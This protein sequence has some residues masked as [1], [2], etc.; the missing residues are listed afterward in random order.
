MGKKGKDQAPA[1]ASAGSFR[2]TRDYDGFMIYEWMWSPDGLGLSLFSSELMLYAKIYSVSHHNTGALTASQGKLAELFGLTRESV[3]RVLK[4]L[5]SRGLIYVCGT[6]RAPGHAGRAVNV[7]AVCQAPINR[8]VRRAPS[9][10]EANQ[11]AQSDPAGAS[12]TPGSRSYV[13]AE[14]P[15]NVTEESPL[16]VT[17]SANVSEASHTQNSHLAGAQPDGA[18]PQ[19]AN[20]TN[21]NEGKETGLPIACR[22]LTQTELLTFESLCKMSLK[23][24]R[25]CYRA[26][27]L[28]DYRAILEDGYSA[29]MVLTAYENY[30]TTLLTSRKRGGRYFPMTLSHFLQ[31]RYGTGAE[32]T[33]N[34]WLQDVYRQ[35]NTAPSTSANA[36][37]METRF[38]LT[39]DGSWV[40]VEQNGVPQFVPGLRE[41]ATRA[42]AVAAWRSHER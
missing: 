17:A 40:A 18:A 21:P 13:T 2:R 14:S 42:D 11:F 6:C 27:T 28:D 19:L 5:V 39:T 15:L 32:K 3:N 30:R 38:I 4:R 22:Q 31:R 33:Y 20:G 41:G 34:T 24:V 26:G 16:N 25:D 7:Y 9:V 35:A 23:P 8:A 29:D 10:S 12:V 36:D 37:G 1:P